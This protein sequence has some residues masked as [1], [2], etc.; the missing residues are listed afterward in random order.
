MNSILEILIIITSRSIRVILLHL[1]MHGTLKVACCFWWLAG[2]IVGNYVLWFVNWISIILTVA[3]HHVNDLRVLFLQ[4]VASSHH[5]NKSLSV[6]IRFGW[7]NWGLMW[8][9]LKWIA[10]KWVFTCLM[11]I[12]NFEWSKLLGRSLA[13]MSSYDVVVVRL[14]NER[15]MGENRLKILIFIWIEIQMKRSIET[16]T[17][18]L[19]AR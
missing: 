13:C 2:V 14:M 17:E 12:L 16:I 8:N 9:V 18:R 10:C 4:L 15:R 11:L 6:R 19:G 1:S 7:I 3:L 5:T